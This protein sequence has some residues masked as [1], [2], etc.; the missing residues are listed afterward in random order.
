MAALMS[1]IVPGTAG[2]AGTALET[3][4]RA[5]SAA[6]GPAASSIVAAAITS[7]TAIGALESRARISADAGGITWEVFTRRGRADAARRASFAGKKDDVRLHEAGLRG[8]STVAGL[9]DLVLRCF[10][11]SMFPGSDGMFGAFMGRL[12]FRFGKIV[13]FGMVCFLFLF[14]CLFLGDL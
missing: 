8:A 5:A 10:G 13:R 2:P 11:V 9:D 12:G 14:V 7:A 1:A 4:S 3:L 6:V